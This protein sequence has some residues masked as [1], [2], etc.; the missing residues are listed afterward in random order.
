[1]AF[2]ATIY[3]VGLASLV[4]LSAHCRQT[5]GHR[6]HGGDREMIDRW[7]GRHRC[8]RQPAHHRRP[9]QGLSA[10]WRQKRRE[11]EHENHERWLVSYADFITLLFLRGHCNAISSVNEGKVPGSQRIHSHAFPQHGPTRRAADPTIQGAPLLPVK[12]MAPDRTRS[13]RIREERSDRKCATSPTTSRIPCNRIAQGKACWKPAAGDHRN[14]RQHPVPAG[15]G[16]AA[17]GPDQCMSHCRRC[18]PHRTFR[19]LSRGIP[20]TLISTPQF[21]SNWENRRPCA[22][23]GAPPVQ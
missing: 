21:P 20:T 2:V 16:R 8:R 15:P 22:D 11:E 3:G 4:Y 19:S 12:P 10:P 7:P 5:Q 9:P 23:D 17:A 18:S 14:Q 1:M 13:G 6:S